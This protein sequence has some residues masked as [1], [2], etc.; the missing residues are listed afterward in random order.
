MT[1]YMLSIEVGIVHILDFLN[2][3]CVVVVFPNFLFDF[4]TKCYSYDLVEIDSNMF[5]DC[6][7]QKNNA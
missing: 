2:I 4:C 5:T 1:L 3:K 6:P 7:A